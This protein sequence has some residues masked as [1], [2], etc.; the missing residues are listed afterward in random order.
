M[1][2]QVCMVVTQ[3]LRSSSV[4]L[5]ALTVVLLC[6]GRPQQ[7][8]LPSC[9]SSFLC[10]ARLGQGAALSLHSSGSELTVAT[11]LATEG[12]Q[13]SL[14]CICHGHTG[15]VSQQLLSGLSTETSSSKTLH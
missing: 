5:G 8:P 14:R 7:T 10:R 4:L 3:W 6:P 13:S 2:W 15:W 12:G 9:P 1:S 11:G